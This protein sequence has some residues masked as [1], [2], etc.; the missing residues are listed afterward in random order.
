MT[1]RTIA[2]IVFTGV[3]LSSLLIALAFADQQLDEKMKAPDR[4]S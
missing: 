1:I 3:V 4:K 2:R